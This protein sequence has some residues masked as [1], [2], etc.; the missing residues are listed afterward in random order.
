MDWITITNT[1]Q[2]DEIV[3]LSNVKPCL[4]Y[5]HSTRCTMSEM[6]K[7]VLE[8]DWDFNIDEIQPYYLDI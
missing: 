5:K 1:Q 4:I 2:L 8:N 6:M 3:K 7:Y